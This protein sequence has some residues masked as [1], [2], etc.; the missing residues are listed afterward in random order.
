MTTL[1]SAKDPEVRRLNYI[2]SKFKL[3]DW[4]ELTILEK[5]GWQSL[6]NR[7]IAD[8]FA[9]TGVVSHHFRK[10]GATVISNDAELYSAII[11]HAFVRSIYTESCR[12]FIERIN[13]ELNTATLEPGFVTKN[14]SP[15]EAC[16]RMFFTSENAL[17]IDYVRTQ[18]DLSAGALSEDEHKFLLASLLVSADAVSNVPAVYGCYLKNFKAKSLKSFVLHPIHDCAVPPEE[19]SVSHHCDVLSNQFIDAVNSLDGG[20]DL[21]YLD[22]PYNERQYSKNYFPLNIIAKSPVAIHPNLKG[23]TGIPDDCF[24]SPF[25]KKG[26][27]AEAAFDRLFRDINA[28]WIILSYS[29]ESL[30]S[31]E[32][33]LE[34]AGKYGEVSVVEREYKRFKSFE[35]NKDLPVTEYLFC[36]RK[37]D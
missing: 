18:I 16:E 14:Y 7:T 1:T 10:K 27:T 26:K 36:L 5:T 32:K 34:L 30:I 22:P 13:R 24:V 25:C 2:G 20:A 17:R 19:S 23:K 21:V 3:I 31:R 33:M 15:F 11:S 12:V 37:R 9:G 29:S 28:R 35:Y 8:A 4:I 6:Q